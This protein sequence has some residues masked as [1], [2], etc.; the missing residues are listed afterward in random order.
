MAITLLTDSDFSAIYK[1][2]YNK[3]QDNVYTTYGNLWGQIRKMYDAGGSEGK[4]PI[5]VSF[6]GGVGSSSDGTLPDA[7]NAAF[8]DPTYNWKRVYARIKI[9]GLTIEASR[10]SEHAFISAVDEET[11]GKIKSFN[12][13]IGGNVPMN[14]G[15]GALGQFSGSTSGTAAAPV[16]TMLTTGTYKY[17]KAYFEK[18]DY[19]NVNSLSSVWEITSINHATP[20]VTLSRISGSDDLTAIGAGTHTM[21]MQNSRNNDPY[22]FKGIIDNSTHYGIAEEYRYSPTEVAAFAAPLE[23]DML[24]ELVENLE[25]DTDE[26]PD[27]LL[28]SPYQFKKYISLL[29]DKK[30]IPVSMTRKPA[31]SEVGGDKAIAKVSYNGITYA[32]RT[33]S[34]IMCMKSK[35]VEDDRVYAINTKHVEAWHVGKK[36]GFQSRMDGLTFLRIDGKDA[37]GAFLA[38][39]GELVI[40]PFYVGC[41]T[42]LKTA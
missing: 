29:E 35:F 16:V 42:G 9:D 32:G 8:L 15:S 10:K 2:Y 36:P 12:R 13:Y 19:V 21:Y 5:R 41:I 1:R 39:Y 4:G 20:A 22:G 6:G 30:Q 23:T 18:G 7:N 14:D 24:N 37:Y 31:K 33:N 34:N 11:T 3:L 17:R 25:T 26:E 40:N 27:I 28:F 38:M